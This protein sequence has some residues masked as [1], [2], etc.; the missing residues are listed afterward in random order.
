[1]DDISSDVIFKEDEDNTVAP[2][3]NP[4]VLRAAPP[5]NPFELRR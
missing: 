1:M 2:T 4:V 3:I 5:A